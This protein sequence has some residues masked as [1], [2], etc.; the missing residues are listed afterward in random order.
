MIHKGAPNGWFVAPIFAAG[1]LVF[2]VSMLPNASYLLLDDDGFELCSLFRKAKVPWHEVETF[3]VG[4]M[5]RHTAV[6]Y[7]HSEA[8]NR[9]GLA[10][11]LARTISPGE[12][13]LPDTYGLKPQALAT[14]MNACKERHRRT[15]TA[16]RGAP[17]SSE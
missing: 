7:Y 6:F 10:K 12:G 8:H 1:A 11:K 17:S 3:F 9:A 13:V 15:Q 2:A 5:A 4:R 14:L 16:V